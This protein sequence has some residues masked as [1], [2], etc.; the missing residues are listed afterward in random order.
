MLPTINTIGYEAFSG[1]NLNSDSVLFKN[2]TQNDLK[3]FFKN[4]EFIEDYAFLKCS[5]IANTLYLPGKLKY[6]GPWGFYNSRVKEVIFGDNEDWSQFYE[7]QDYWNKA[8]SSLPVFGNNNSLN[9]IYFYVENNN[10]MTEAR[11]TAILEGLTKNSITLD[12]GRGEE[13]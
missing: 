3:E 12:Y 6:I 8:D 7:N 2:A 4:I 1:R 5:Y 11:K 10:D 13:V 9:K